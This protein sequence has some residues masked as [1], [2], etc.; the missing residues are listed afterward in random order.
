M[1]YLK[2]IQNN[3]PSSRKGAPEQAFFFQRIEH[4]LPEAVHSVALWTRVTL[5]HFG[6]V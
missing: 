5:Q 1:D 4:E 6:H 3:G 2:I